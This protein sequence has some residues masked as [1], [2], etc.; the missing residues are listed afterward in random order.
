MGDR[1]GVAMLRCV[2]MRMP[3]V[4]PSLASATFL[5]VAAPAL[6]FSASVVH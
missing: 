5:P 2:L 6:G 3:A 1:K 4:I